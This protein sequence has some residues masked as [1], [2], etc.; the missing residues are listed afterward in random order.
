[1]YGKFDNK[2]GFNINLMK[3]FSIIFLLTL[4]S[5]F[6]FI[7]SIKISLDVSRSYQ[8][9]VYC[10]A[11]CLPHIYLQIKIAQ[12]VLYVSMLN[13]GFHTITKK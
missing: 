10:V 5:S 1:M 7:V 3:I 9:L 2:T 6:S 8:D 4:I 12:Y 11:R 13:F